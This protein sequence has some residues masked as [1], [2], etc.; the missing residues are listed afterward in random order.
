MLTS[1]TLKQTLVYPAQNR[2]FIFFFAIKVWD[3]KTKIFV[4]IVALIFLKIPLRSYAFLFSLSFYE[5]IFS[6]AQTCFLSSQMHH[7]SYA[8]FGLFV[9]I[10]TRNADAV[11]LY[12]FFACHIFF[13]QQNTMISLKLSSNFFK[14]HTRTHTYWQTFSQTAV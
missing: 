2:L 9:H 1:H 8:R 13:L 3:G 11:R 10:S 14:T 4:Y 12:F 5:N 7:I 6:T